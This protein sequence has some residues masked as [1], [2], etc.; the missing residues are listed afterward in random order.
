MDRAGHPPGSMKT[1]EMIALLFL[2]YLM[3]GIVY[4][5]AIMT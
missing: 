2:D 5:V 4:C 3:S 1:T